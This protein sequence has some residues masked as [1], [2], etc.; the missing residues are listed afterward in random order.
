MRL[1]EVRPSHHESIRQQSYVCSDVTVWWTYSTASLRRL[2]NIW[3]ALWSICNILSMWL[4]W[5]WHFL[6]RLTALLLWWTIS[7]STFHFSD[8]L[9]FKVVKRV[10]YNLA[11]TFLVLHTYSTQREQFCKNVAYLVHFV[12]VQKHDCVVYLFK[13]ML[14]SPHFFPFVSGGSCMSCQKINLPSTLN[15]RGERTATCR[16]CQ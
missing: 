3:G 5:R 1:V 12:L 6:S 9:L 8:C 11:F 2:H 15:T 13:S 10:A 14:P 4:W 7:S 16:V